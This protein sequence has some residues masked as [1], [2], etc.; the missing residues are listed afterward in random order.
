[1]SGLPVITVEIAPTAG[2]ATTSPT[3]VDV[4]SYVYLPD[5]IRFARGNTDER[6]SAQP[7]AAAVTFKNVGG[8][9]SPG[10]TSGAYHPLKLRV[11]I[12]FSMTPPGGSKTVMW[13]GLVDEWDVMPGGGRPLCRV[14]ASDRLAQLGRVVL[15]CWETEQH[16]LA[17]PTYLWPFTDPA[18]STTVGEVAS[19]LASAGNILSTA[20]V[21][22][23]GSFELSVGGL[24]ID[25]GTVAAFNPVDANN[26]V[27]LATAAATVGG[28]Y[29]GHTFSVLMN[30]VTP[31]NSVLVRLVDGYTAYHSLEITSAGKAKVVSH[32]PFSTTVSATSTTTVTDGEWHL[33]T[34]VVESGGDLAIRV[35]GTE[36][37]TTTANGA[38]SAR[39]IYVGG[40]PTGKCFSGQLSHA[41]AWVDQSY[42]SAMVNYPLA[43]MSGG[44]GD[45]TTARHLDLCAFGGIT[46]A[47]VGTGVS[48]LGAQPVAGSTLLDAL[49]ACAASELAPL[50]VSA[51]GAPTLAG[52]DERYSA[53]VDMSF[54]AED[55][56]PQTPFTVNDERLTNDV[57]VQRTNAADQRATNADSIAQYGRHSYTLSLLVDSEAQQSAIAQWLANQNSEPAARTEQ[58]VIDAWVNDNIDLEDLLA[59]DVG[60]RIAV[61]DLP[62]DAT[63]DTLDLFVEGF[64][65]EF[66]TSGWRRTLNT[67]PVGAAGSVWILDDTTYSVLDSTTI[68]AA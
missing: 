43:A 17:E 51:S 45:T 59:L 14:R 13:T 61:T 11:P 24:P 10:N 31:E 66:S 22:T 41:S 15:N 36:E 52:R 60:S 64:T 3:W 26:G 58:L 19:G 50:Y 33:I 7:G 35:D 53:P 48:T 21:G 34:L 65:D 40:T 28:T 18:G 42:A 47:V 6:S 25:E 27:Y 4:S 57:T 67:S 20:Q 1:M 8:R 39:T 32:N 2:A 38:F 12:R 55:V 62:S 30:S 56:S 16:L 44:V 63:S 54:S 49:N 5:G 68:L 29:T 46:G 37:A 9:F 23:G